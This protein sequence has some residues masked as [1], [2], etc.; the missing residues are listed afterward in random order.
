MAGT[1]EK[2]GRTVA[3]FV[4]PLTM[5]TT[6]YSVRRAADTHAT[7]SPGFSS[8]MSP[9]DTSKTVVL[10]AAVT[11]TSLPPLLATTP[12]D[13]ASRSC[14]RVRLKS[15]PCVLSPLNASSKSPSSRMA[16]SPFDK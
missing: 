16:G 15:M 14:R 11:V 5:V 13:D 4:P 9:P 12:S 2:A 1:V 8:A 7:T 3:W 10:T 6:A